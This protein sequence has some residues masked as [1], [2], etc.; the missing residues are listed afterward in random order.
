MVMHVRGEGKLTEFCI[1]RR[2]VIRIRMDLRRLSISNPQQQSVLR[3]DILTGSDRQHKLPAHEVVEQM[4]QVFQERLMQ[5]VDLVRIQSQQLD[6][7]VRTQLP[8]MY[9]E[10]DPPALPL[11]VEMKKAK[12]EKLRNIKSSKLSKERPSKANGVNVRLSQYASACQLGCSCACHCTTKSS[13]PNF[14]NSLIGKMFVA[15]VGVPLLSPK[16]NLVDCERTQSPAIVVEY[17]FPFRFCW[18]KIIQLQLAYI[19]NMG[20]K[21]QV[22]TLRQVPDS[23][24]CVQY[25][26]AGNIDGLKD[27]FIRGLASPMDISTT[28]G[29]TMVRVRS[30]ILL[31][32]TVIY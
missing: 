14:V 23:A 26:M 2:D 7:N 18:S 10:H 30:L 24:Q 29:Y 9:L 22:K 25:A 21:V 6:T 28:R 31:L 3:G 16:C 1:Y 17:W 15:Y 11:R 12:T 32:E 27:L 19:S 20:P 13:T 5:V 4:G 8:S